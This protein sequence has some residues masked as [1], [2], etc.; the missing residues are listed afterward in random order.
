VVTQA[1]W[2]TR[3]MD[4]TTRLWSYRPRGQRAVTLS[5]T[6]EQA[7]DRLSRL[8]ASHELVPLF[9]PKDLLA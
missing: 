3:G 9:D 8:P 1:V 2:Y 6:D 5:M 4:T 7:L